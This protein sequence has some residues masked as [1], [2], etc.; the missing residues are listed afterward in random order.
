M[1]R[2]A[3]ATILLLACAIAAPRVARADGVLAPAARSDARQRYS[4]GIELYT[5]ALRTHDRATFE[6]AY[7]EFVQAFAIYPDDKVLWNLAVSANDTGRYV[8]ALKYFRTFDEHQHALA[9]E[10][11]AQH[12]ALRGYMESLSSKTSQLDVAAPTGARVLVD[13]TVVGTAPLRTPIDVLPGAHD[14]AVDEAGTLAHMSVDAAAG[15]RKRVRIGFVEAPS[16][17][18]VQPAPTLTVA[19]APAQVPVRDVVATHHPSFFTT[20]NTLVVGLAAG[21][22]AAVVTGTLFSVGARNNASTETTVSGQL[23]S[24]ACPGAPQCASLSRAAS[25]RASDYNAAT[26]LFITGGALA[27]TGVAL[28]LFLHDAPSTSSDGAVHVT[29]SVTPST[30]GLQLTGTF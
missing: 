3:C 23:G 21:T 15:E 17:P 26:G 7:L 8:E 16:A 24:A 4:K 11:H 10:A 9:T 19:V 18:V 20:R 1:K 29:P 27:A 14:V 13:G 25:D 12:A 22:V 2:G 30:A 5:R 28:L 6:A